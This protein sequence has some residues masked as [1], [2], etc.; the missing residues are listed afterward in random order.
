VSDRGFGSIFGNTV[1]DWVRGF[2]TPEVFGSLA[3]MGS[4]LIEDAEDLTTRWST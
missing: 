4:R 1:R 3:P 2:D